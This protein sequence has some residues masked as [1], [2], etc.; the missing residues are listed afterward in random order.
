MWPFKCTKCE[1]LEADIKAERK[2]AFQLRLRILKLN[3]EIS[4]LKAITIG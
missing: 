3:A 1:R 4:R 2:H